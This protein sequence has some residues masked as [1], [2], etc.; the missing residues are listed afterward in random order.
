MDDIF[1]IGLVG[2][3]GLGKSTVAEKISNEKKIVFL[4]SKDITRPILKKY[5]YVY[6]DEPVELFLS[7]KEIEYEIIDER[8]YAE[9]LLC[10]G[11]ITDRT[12]LEC[13]CYAMLNINK[14]SDDEI[15]MLEKICRANADKYTHIFY[16]PYQTGWFEDNG[17]RTTSV[18][19]Q[20][21]IDILIRG[22]LADW[23]IN[24]HV[25]PDGIENINRFICEKL[26]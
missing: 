7:R 23:K 17:L 16:F 26:Y 14:Y 1:K 19:F 11:F 10:G 21:K 8:I 24:H 13:F 25:V 9:E 3:A 12:T 5:K 6:G 15:K 18:Y 22:I 2:C 20:W 4:R